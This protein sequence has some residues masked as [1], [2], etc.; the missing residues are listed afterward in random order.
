M[1]L[2]LRASILK[3]KLADAIGTENFGNYAQVKSEMLATYGTTPSS[4]W[5]EMHE[6]KQ[7]QETFRQYALRGGRLVRRWIGL[8]VESSA[9]K[10]QVLEAIVRHLV[11]ESANPKLAAYLR[12]ECEKDSKMEEFVEAG[13]IISPLLRKRR[14]RSHRSQLA[15]TIHRASLLRRQTSPPPP[16]PPT[17]HHGVL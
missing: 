4:A 16:P 7:G 12:R 9:T 17:E 2:F 1:G 10:E 15:E 3:S 5:R 11:L 13:G 14:L 8:V 6:A